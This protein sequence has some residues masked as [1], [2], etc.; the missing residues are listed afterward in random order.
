M[1]RSNGLQCVTRAAIW[2]A[3]ILSL[4]HAAEWA[5]RGGPVVTVVPALRDRSEPRRVPLVSVQ[6]ISEPSWCGSARARPRLS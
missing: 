4:G 5:R 3:S 6:R 1:S 2:S